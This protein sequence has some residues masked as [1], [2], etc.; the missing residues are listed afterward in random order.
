MERF[1]GATKRFSK[2]R[3]MEL[4]AALRACDLVD[5]NTLSFHHQLRNGDR[6]VNQVAGASAELGARGLRIAPTA[7]FDVHRPIIEHVESGVVA[8]IE[9][10]LNGA[11]GDYVSRNPLPSPVVLR[12][13]GCRWAA[14]QSL[15]LPVDIAIVAASAA[16]ERGNCTGL[17]GPSA[18][19]PLAYSVVDAVHARHVVV[20]T[21]NLVD[22][23]CPMWEVD[24]RYV[25]AVVVLDSIG[26]PGGIA[27]GSLSIPTDTVRRTIAESCVDFMDRAG[28]IH[29]GMVMQAGAGGISLLAMDRLRTR[30]EERGET[31]KMFTGGMTS[32][33]VDMFNAGTVSSLR[34]SQAF[35]SQS[36]AF[37]AEHP[38]MNADIGLY[39]DASAKAR[40]IDS[41][42]VVVLGATEV[43]VGFNANVNT[44]SDGRLLH[45]IGGHQDTAQ[46]ASVTIIGV[47]LS[48]R[49]NPIVRDAVTTITTP[50][51]V[52]DVVVTDDGIAVNP[53]RRDLIERIG[54][55][56]SLR[57]MEELRDIAYSVTGPPGR[58]R[59]TDQP[60]A[61]IRWTDGT[62]LDTVYRRAE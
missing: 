32:F 54:D 47:P 43:D 11:V 23:P 37:M 58:M 4:D 7:L 33:L 19:G 46:S 10:S 22:Y 50:G 21:D 3:V 31:V 39:A 15:E 18:F 56:I 25:D 45:G 6:V 26:D 51:S 13:H 48:R 41:L 5:G 28:L 55:A 30:L 20:V 29:N 1:S 14:V 62:L 60:V 17:L 49:D 8:Q 36:V 12:S 38:E 40:L 34:C 24:E 61:E 57:T 59:W 42:D 27:S 53:S 52:V 2:S 9:G 16:D 44:H 35:D